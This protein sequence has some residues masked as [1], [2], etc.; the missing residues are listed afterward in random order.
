MGDLRGSAAGTATSGG[1]DRAN[2]MK[3]RCKAP[4]PEQQVVDIA[5]ALD[6]SETEVVERLAKALED[7]IVEPLNVTG[8]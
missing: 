3:F 6:I 1:L 5:R 8:P 7:R 2:G 4:P